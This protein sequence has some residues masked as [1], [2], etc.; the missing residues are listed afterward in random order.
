MITLYTSGSTDD[1]K[2]V[3]HKDI[4]SYAQQS[5]KEIGLTSSDVVLDVFPANVIAHYTVTALPALLS[6]AHLVSANFSPYSYISLFN[7][8]KPTYISLIPKHWEL[9]KSTKG[10]NDFDMGSVRYMVTGSSKISQEMIDDFRERGVKTVANWYGMT[11]MP[12]PVMV[13][14]NTTSFD[15]NTID[16]NKYHVMFNPV[17]ATSSLAE[18]IINGWSTGDIFD[19]T[20]KTFSHRRTEAN[21]NT[22]KA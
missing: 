19:M 3:T 5:I 8:I 22:W 16:S 11:E 1:P 14:Y 13:G 9:L 18:C 20:T 21:G 7:Q 2:K 15:F 10:W 4:N 17:T 12:P 6:G